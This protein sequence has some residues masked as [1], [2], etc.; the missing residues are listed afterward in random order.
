MLLS[1]GSAYTWRSPKGHSCGRTVTSQSMIIWLEGLVTLPTLFKKV[2][3]Q[4]FWECSTEAL[5]SSLAPWEHL[6]AYKQLPEMH[7]RKQHVSVI[8]W[9]WFS[10][11]R[12]HVEHYTNQQAWICHGRQQEQCVS[13]S[14]ASWDCQVA[15]SLNTKW[16]QSNASIC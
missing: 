3:W 15:M 13:N 2:S 11:N 9:H 5:Q 7:L 14:Q 16:L 1:N 10:S 4:L 8:M 12:W 6:R